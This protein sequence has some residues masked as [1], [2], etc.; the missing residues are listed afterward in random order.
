M[1]TG[2]IEIRATHAPPRRPITY[3]AFLEWLDED[4][5][6]E[7]VD[8]KVIVHMPATDRHQLTL[9][10]IQALLLLYVSRLKLG[11]VFTA[12]FPMRLKDIPS[13]REPDLMV[14]VN[15]HLAR[16][17]RQYLDGPADLVVE[18]VSN[19]SVRRDRH[20]KLREYERAG[21]T[22]Y[23]VIDPRVGR[24]RADFYRLN[25]HGGY[26]LFATEDD[27]RVEIAVLPG[28]WLRPSWLWQDATVDFLQAYLEIRGLTAEQAAQI[29]KLL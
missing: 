1:T 20:E 4:V 11:R 5:H 19:D 7:W 29:D 16:V 10:F 22:E 21:V 12:P 26:D 18:I 14:V 2:E 25:E 13:Q 15:E 9:G 8:G 17:Q 3:E 23:W 24:Q 6:A 28:F 27:E